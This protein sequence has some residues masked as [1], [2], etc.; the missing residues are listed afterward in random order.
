[1]AI[2]I[3]IPGMK[4]ILNQLYGFGIRPRRPILPMTAEKGNGIM[5]NEDMMALFDFEAKLVLEAAHE[6]S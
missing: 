1:V 5:K 6:A 3:G 4:M 2:K